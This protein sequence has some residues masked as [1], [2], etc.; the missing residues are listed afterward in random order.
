MFHE[1]QTKTEPCFTRNSAASPL[2]GFV[3]TSLRGSRVFHEK[4]TCLRACAHSSGG[5]HWQL[6]C[7]CLRSALVASNQW[8]PALRSIRRPHPAVL[9]QPHRHQSA[10]QSTNQSTEKVQRLFGCHRAALGS[11]SEAARVFDAELLPG[12]IGE[13][14]ETPQP[15]HGAP[16]FGDI[17]GVLTLLDGTLPPALPKLVETF[18]LDDRNKAFKPHTHF[19]LLK[20]VPVR[21]D[22]TDGNASERDVLESTSHPGRVCVMDR[23]YV[24]FSMFRKIVG[25]GSSFVCCFRDNSA[26]QVL[27]GRP[28]SNRPSFRTGCSNREARFSDAQSFHDRSRYR[29][30]AIG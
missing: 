16:A 8:H 17:Q 21:M 24:K 13:L 3:A 4:L 1:K 2:R 7:Q 12:V 29:M 5:W 28:L 26:F 19:E 15:L 23:G 6:A 27:E 20:G 22:P 18:W 30:L 14:V 11:L 9:L 25:I 10:G